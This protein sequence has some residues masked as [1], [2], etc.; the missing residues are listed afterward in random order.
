MAGAAVPAF[1]ASSG[2]DVALMTH[3]DGPHLSAYISGL[4]KTPEVGA[5]YLCDPSGATERAVREALGSKVSGF[6]RSPRELFRARKPALALITMEAKVTPPAIDAALGAGCHVMAEKPA[7]V[8]TEDFAPLAA[9]AAAGKRHLMLAL[10]NRVD[11]VM[12]EAKRIV[13][14]G[15]IGK[16]YGMVL[17]TIA[18]QT[19]LTSPAYHKTWIAQKSRAGG[20]HLIWLGIHWLDLAMYI[21]GSAITEV[22]GFTANVGGQPIDT[23]DAAAISFRFA[24]GTLATIQSGY[25]LDKNKQLFIKVWGSDG[26]VEVNHGTANPLEWYSTKGGKQRSGKYAPPPGPSGYDAWVRHVVRA[27]ADLEAPVLTPAESLRALRVVFA[28]YR[29]AET[30]QTQKVI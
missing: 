21:S 6:Y 1:A 27:G 14:S 13:Q 5:V 23:E 8:R 17:H 16:V 25:Y 7:C 2:V 11:V 30:G 28:S 19:R 29:A 12:L 3:A 4:A 26:W 9:K 10:A 15:E 18:D 22:A 24:N 20:G